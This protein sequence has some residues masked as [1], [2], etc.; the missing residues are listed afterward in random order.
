MET[1]GLEG[2][3]GAEDGEGM[4][5][6]CREGGEARNL[7]KMNGKKINGD[8]RMDTHDN[9][10]RRADRKNAGIAIYTETRAAPPCDEP[11]VRLLLVEDNPDDARLIQHL[12]AKS[13][14]ARFEC[15]HAGT[16]REASLALGRSAFDAVLLDLELPDSVGRRTFTEMHSEAPEIPIIILSG[17]DDVELA[18]HIVHDGAQD[19]L[20]KDRIDS[21]MLARSI[22]YALERKRAELALASERAMLRGLIDSLPDFIYVKDAEGRYLLDNKA[23]RALVGAKTEQEVVGRTAHAFFPA[24]IAARYTADDLRCM[25]SGEAILNQIEP[26]TVSKG[27]IRWLAT[28]KVPLRDPEGRSRMLVCVGQDITQ[29]KQIED[30]LEQS[31]LRFRTLATQAPVGIFQTDADGDC[32]FVNERWCRITGMPPEAALMQ[33][34]VNAFHPDDRESVLKQWREAAEAGAEFFT[35]C[36]FRRPDGG[37]A[38][39]TVSALPLRDEAG[40]V[41]GHIGTVT[42]ITAQKRME[43]EI[44]EIADAEQRRI[45]H[46]LHDGL[47]QHLVATA[48]ASRIL[49][50]KLARSNLPEAGD[51]N[52]ISCLVG[53]AIGQTR[54]LSKGLSPVHFEEHSLVPVF[55]ELACNMEKL[56]RIPCAVE[57]DGSVSLE[58]SKTA[59]HLH[60][61]VREA[62]GNAMKHARPKGVK[63]HL[64][65]QDGA[66]FVRVA[67]DGTGICL[68]AGSPDGMGMQI[69]KYRAH[70]IGASLD[71]RP[72]PEGGTVVTCTL[73]LPDH[74]ENHPQQVLA[75][76]G[77]D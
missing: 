49:E 28:T 16:L 64:Q 18:L 15:K 71:I 32:L 58:D 36:R 52:T 47:C 35:T 5:S 29:R 57:C 56:F 67:D 33:G 50:E 9:G 73:P 74:E 44:V 17:L 45:G 77:E 11:V 43:N 20:V 60:R 7:G 27:G 48:F 63:I 68:E 40:I 39:G 31:E 23:H 41:C 70:Q 10:N 14:L 6:L 59:M 65:V 55:R 62:V 22:R 51:A 19:Y 3:N 21:E 76:V 53:E 61:I 46:E 66:L 12:L 54:A 1:N 8:D 25:E 24:E 4:R 34:W 37:D 72:L 69:M 42:D 75:C 38:W 30:A 2:S 13:P 26:T